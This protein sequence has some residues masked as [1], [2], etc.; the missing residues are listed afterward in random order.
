M[1]D[2]SVSVQATD[3]G[4]TVLDLAGE[5]DLAGA[6]AM[7]TAGFAALAEPGCSTLILD[8]AKLTFVDSTGIGCWIE[9][10]KHARQHDQRFVL[11][12]PSDNL[13]R[14]LTMAGLASILDVVGHPAAEKEA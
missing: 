2:F 8:V 10:R 9:L 5:L 4:S 12:G 3:S 6:R 1:T 13:T 7:R 14:I 11:R